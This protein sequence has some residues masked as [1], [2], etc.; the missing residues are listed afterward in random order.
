LRALALFNRQPFEIKVD[1][2]LLQEKPDVLF[3]IWNVRLPR[4]RHKVEVLADNT[5]TVILEKTSMYS[6]R[7]IVI[8]GSV[9]CGLMMLIYI[10]ILARRAI[11]RAVRS[12]AQSSNP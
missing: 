11:G 6:S 5:A 7:L 12:R 4:G 8:F 1:G 10:S 3:G 2:Q 9:A